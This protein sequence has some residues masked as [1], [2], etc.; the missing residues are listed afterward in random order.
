MINPALTDRFLR[1]TAFYFLKRFTGF[2]SINFY[3]YFERGIAS[4]ARLG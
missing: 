2:I 1:T 3:S 4:Q